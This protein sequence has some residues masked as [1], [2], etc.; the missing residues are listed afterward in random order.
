MMD[1]P[2]FRSALIGGGVFGV[3]A[4]VP[5]PSIGLLSVAYGA[6]YVGGG[7]LAAYLYVKDQTA[8]MESRK[9][10]GAQVGLMAGAVGGVVATI[11]GAIVWALAFSPPRPTSMAPSFTLCG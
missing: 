1:N 9:D 6:L 7:V 8:P 4:A 10:D 5:L 2:K 3:A 11:V